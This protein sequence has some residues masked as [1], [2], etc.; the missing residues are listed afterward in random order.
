MWEYEIEGTS[1]FDDHS[2]LG[3]IEIILLS[4]FD[5]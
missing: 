1:S 4:F 5:E 3:Q 2:R